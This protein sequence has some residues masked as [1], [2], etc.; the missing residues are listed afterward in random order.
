MESVSGGN[1]DNALHLK[2]VIGWKYLHPET[3]QL[4]A[5]AFYGCG[6]AGK[7]LLFEVIAAE[8]FGSSNACRRSF[9]Q[10]EKFSESIVGKTI[11]FFDER[12]GRD[13]ES[14]MK[15][16][17]GQPTL[18]IEPKGSAVYDVE[19]TALYVIATNGDQGPVR[20]EKNGTERRWSIIKTRDR[21]V[22]VIAK[23]EGCTED[24]ANVMIKMA[25]QHVY[26]NKDEV[27]YFLHTCIEEA[28]KLESAPL[29]LHSD[30]FDELI[31]IQRDVV[32]ELVEEVFVDYAAFDYIS[33]T[34]L[35]N[36]YL[37]KTRENNPSA[38]PMSIQT[39]N[40]KI[41]N[42]LDN[43][44][45]KIGAV[46]KR[47]KNR[48]SI[49]SGSKFLNKTWVYYSTKNSQELGSYSDNSAK[50]FLGAYLSE[51]TPKDVEKMGNVVRMS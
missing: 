51:K 42:Y 11:V 15:Y 24:E 14:T 18:S 40:A 22:D 7:N 21:L 9:K 4:P 49:K 28:K 26:R 32:D 10:V 2:Q 38:N 12:P 44:K 47:I 23:G 48:A 13:D 39:F 34:T 16:F 43:N 19:N 46:V 5:I 36:M 37:T 50:Y 25:D 20:I 33:L 17:I 35:Y 41:N 3:W 27:A 1:A 31:E 30:D 29:A 6:G 8:I 45:T